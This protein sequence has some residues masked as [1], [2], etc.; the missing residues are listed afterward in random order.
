MALWSGLG[1]AATA[2]Q[3]VGVDLGGLISNI[4]QAA[5]TARQN[6]KECEQ[7]AGRVSMIDEILSQMQESD[8]TMQKLLTGLEN[9]LREA[10]RLIVSCQERSAAYRFVMA[11]RQA[12]KLREAQ[13]RIDG[14]LGLFPMASHNITMRRFDEYYNALNPTGCTTVPC[15][16]YAGARSQRQYQAWDEEEEEQWATFYREEEDQGAMFYR[17]EEK[18]KAIFYRKEEDQS[19]VFYREED[20]EQE[21]LFT[22]HGEEQEAVFCRDEEDAFYRE[23][24]E[25]EGQEAAFYREEEKQ[26]RMFTREEERGYEEDEDEEAVF[27]RDNEDEDEDEEQVFYRDNED[28]DEE[29]VFYKKEQEEG[30]TGAAHSWKLSMHITLPLIE[31]HGRICSTF[32]GVN[33]P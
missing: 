1:E 26:E 27:Y 8:E 2:A 16:T 6:K 3:L 13:R 22:G 5:A 20:V 24:D 12:D 4:I 28:E 9:E 11:K 23:E 32:V 33:Q 31:V 15:N 19:A 25:Q 14:Y 7:L 29:A 30:N 18:S 17:E 10:H 21:T